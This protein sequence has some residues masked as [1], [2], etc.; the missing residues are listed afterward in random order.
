S[1]AALG[2]CDDSASAGLG[3]LPR[4]TNDAMERDGL[5]LIRL[6]GSPE[7]YE[8][9]G[10]RPELA[11]LR[12]RLQQTGVQSGSIE[13]WRRLNLAAGLPEIWPETREAFTPHMLNLD[14][15]GAVSFKK[16]CYPGQEVVAKT[17]HRGLAKRRLYSAFCA[18]TT[19]PAPGTRVLTANDQH[20]GDVVE[21]VLGPDNQCQLSA[22]LMLE[23]ASDA[24]L[25]LPGSDSSLQIQPPPYSLEQAQG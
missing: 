24:G 25:R 3:E 14:L 2:V 7:R 23:H 18:V 21:A 20:A 13:D 4:A 22:V 9:W 16:G 10:T 12:A 19:P 1:W 6:P 5:T 8:I 15:L 11:A 17:Q